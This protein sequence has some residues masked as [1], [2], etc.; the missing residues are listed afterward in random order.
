[1]DR[2][3]SLCISDSYGCIE[4]GADPRLN[5]WHILNYFPGS[6][7]EVISASAG[8]TVSTMVVNVSDDNTGNKDLDLPDTNTNLGKI[9]TVRNS[10]DYLNPGFITYL[11][12]TR[13][14][15]GTVDQLQIDIMT[16]DPGGKADGLG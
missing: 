3:N 8:T 2:F 11:R 5:V 14:G 10:S 7:P 12:C 16:S 4:L 1:M 15:S 9:I 6:S 13:V